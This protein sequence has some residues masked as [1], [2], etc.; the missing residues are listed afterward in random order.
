LGANL[1]VVAIFATKQFQ[2][3]AAYRNI[4]LLTRPL[5]L[6]I[7]GLT[8]CVIR[9][10]VMRDMIG[11]TSIG[12]KFRL[13]VFEFG[14]LILAAI[15][16]TAAGNIINDY[17][18][19]KVDR[20][21]KPE[22]VIVG[23]TVKRRVA[24]VLHQGL[25]IAA[26]LMT[27]FVC[28]HNDYYW[29]ILIPILIAT[30]LWWYSPLFKKKV[31]IG[32]FV[33]AL[34]TASVPIW[35]AIFEI[36]ALSK[37]YKDMLVQSEV[38]FNDMWLTILG[39]SAFA[40]LLTLVREAVKDMEDLVGDKSGEYQ[41]LP[42][43]YGIAKTKTYSTVLMAVFTISVVIAAL[44][45]E[46]RLAGITAAVILLIPASYITLRIRMAQTSLQFH[47]CSSLLKTLVII[48]LVLLVVLPNI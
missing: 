24:I 10:S 17:F 25:N 28:M 5:N 48:G 15:A 3:L 31:F 42:I 39:I 33:V 4:F 37:Y 40:F 30:L 16:L 14:L 2:Q 13:S 22:N 36:Q 43:V 19:Q 23:K 12:M 8:M 44:Q 32:N 29:P 6:M 7:V 45:M 34:C 1:K 26:V 47:K 46:N 21:N 38:F 35:A 9:Y 11:E 41:T 20:I 18:D 27:L